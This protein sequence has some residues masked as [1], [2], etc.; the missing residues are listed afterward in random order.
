MTF[1]ARFRRRA[2]KRGN[3]VAGNS[4]DC[5]SL[6]AAFLARDDSNSRKW[7]IQTLCQQAPQRLVRAIFERRRSEFHLQRAGMFAF[8]GIAAGS[9]HNSHGED[10]LALAFD[11][12]NQDRIPS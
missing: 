4:R 6:G 8:N 7:H 10:N 3:L 9:R 12:F 1:G 11:E 5:H 2:A